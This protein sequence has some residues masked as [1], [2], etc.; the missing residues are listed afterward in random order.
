MDGFALLGLLA[1]MVGLVGVF[2]LSR[3]WKKPR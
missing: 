1:I 3:S 2:I